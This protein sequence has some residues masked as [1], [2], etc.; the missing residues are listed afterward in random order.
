MWMLSIFVIVARFLS[1]KITRLVHHFDY[2]TTMLHSIV[3]F[4]LPSNDIYLMVYL[5]QMKQ[6][7]PVKICSLCSERNC[8]EK[9]SALLYPVR[10]FV[11][12][13]KHREQTIPLGC[14]T[15]KTWNSSVLCHALFNR[16]REL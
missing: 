9:F 13:A 2:V 11:L 6:R 16:R 14:E 7:A 12:R 3:R 15:C 1:W 10:N 4:G 8:W 5:M